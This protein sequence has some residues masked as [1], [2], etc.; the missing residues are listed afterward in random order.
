MGGSSIGGKVFVFL[1]VRS[2]V[3]LFVCFFML[4]RLHPFPVR[5]AAEAQA[6]NVACPWMHTQAFYPAIRPTYIYA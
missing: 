5:D 1:F 2:F 4:H 3:C 6:A